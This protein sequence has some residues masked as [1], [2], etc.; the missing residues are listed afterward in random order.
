MKNMILSFKTIGV[1]CIAAAALAA[2]GGGGADAPATT[3]PPSTDVDAPPVANPDKFTPDFSDVTTH[4]G[5]RDEDNALMGFYKGCFYL[6]AGSSF[7]VRNQHIANGVVTKETMSSVQHD[8]ATFDGVDTIAVVN[9]RGDGTIESREHWILGESYTVFGPFPATPEVILTKLAAERFDLAGQ[10][11]T[12][13]RY[14]AF[15]LYDFPVVNGGLVSA[16]RS[17]VTDAATGVTSE[18]W[19][20]RY[21][22]VFRGMQG[23]IVAGG[24]TYSW[25]CRVDM[26]EEGVPSRKSWF[27]GGR[28][29]VK[30]ITYG[31]DGL[32]VLV[33]EQL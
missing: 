11:V 23:S 26:N 30:T 7:A 32:P 3:F 21:E 1:L 4:M 17:T 12:T 13:V 5:R 27:S 22:F 2:C 16:G 14:S 33:Q 9:K 8:A 18:D 28:G 19:T 31:D 24:K 25:T 20:S 29:A 10:L 6:K 15:K